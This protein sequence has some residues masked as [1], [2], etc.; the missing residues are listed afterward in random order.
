MQ[1]QIVWKKTWSTSCLLK[2]GKAKCLSV[3]RHTGRGSVYFVNP[4]LTATG[5]E[6]WYL[7]QQFGILTVVLF[8]CL[9]EP[10]FVINFSETQLRSL[11]L[12]TYL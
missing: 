10:Q 11:G 4:A 6:S 7:K 8:K 5:R 12:K 9:S 1:R 3:L 2:A